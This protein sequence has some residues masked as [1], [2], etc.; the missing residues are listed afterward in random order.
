MSYDIDS[1]PRRFRVKEMDPTE[2]LG[3]AAAL[4]VLL[5]FSMKTMVPLRVAGIFSNLFFIA[6]AY[7]TDAHPILILHAILLPLNVMRLAQILSLLRK[8]GT[9][10]PWRTRP[11]SSGCRWSRRTGG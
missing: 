1:T 7:Q 11:T 8:V 6:Y 3:Y 2:L 4:L 9:L 10:R 5:T